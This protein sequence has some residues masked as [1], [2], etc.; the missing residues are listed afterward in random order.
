MLF[1]CPEYM[2]VHVRGVWGLE[3]WSWVT[4]KRESQHVRERGL[5][6][7][8]SPTVVFSR[9]AS[10]GFAKNSNKN[11]ILSF[12][13]GFQADTTLPSAPELRG[14]CFKFFPVG[15]GA[16][17]VRENSSGFPSFRF[18]PK[19]VGLKSERERRAMHWGASG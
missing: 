12:T 15:I 6:R 10:K 11:Q 2:Q 9:C 16:L 3:N 1:V 4:Y 7:Q 17:N 13:C 8:A 14:A 5:T 19:R 18:Q